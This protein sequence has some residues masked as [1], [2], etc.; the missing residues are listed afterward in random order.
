VTGESGLTFDG[1]TLTIGADS[2]IANEKLTI[3]ESHSN[4]GTLSSIAGGESNTIN[5]GAHCSTIAGGD[6]NKI[7][8]NHTHAFIGGGH[9]NRVDGGNHSVLVGGIENCNDGGGCSVL[10]GGYSNYNN[11]G[12]ASVI[13]GGY[14]NTNSVS[15][16][17]LGAGR[18]NCVGGS[19]SLVVGGHEN[20]TTLNATASSIVG[21][22]KNCMNH[23]CGFIGGGCENSLFR[24][25]M[26]ATNNS[27]IVGGM[28]NEVSSS[29]SFVAG[30][31]CNIIGESL[32]NT[33]IVGSDITA[34]G[35][36]VTHV[37]SLTYYAHCNNTSFLGTAN[38]AG[39]IIYAGTSTV[40]AGDVY[41]LAEPSSGTSGWLQ[42]DADA[43][44]TSKGML[45]IALGSGASQDVGMLVR[46]FARFTSD[47]AITGATMGS[48][49]YLSTTAGDI[50]LTAPSGTGDIVRIIGH[51]IDDTTETIYFNPDNS[52][53]EIG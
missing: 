10:V 32:H 9:D 42:A 20:T 48:P 6:T 30:G 24:P 22:R 26:S 35:A 41:V 39:E 53:I 40:S 38:V 4:S 50:T 45:A 28:K 34:L 14:D 18:A 19:C 13:V 49:V 44:S 1:T 12:F 17:F 47:F 31:C 29:Y 46:G 7:C 51:V 11:G 27:S 23:P 21:G 2:T 15:Y 33:F 52:Y 37:N 16:S 3:G 25:T 43:E 5:T 8:A 36:C